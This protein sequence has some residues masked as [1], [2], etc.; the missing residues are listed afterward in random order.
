MPEDARERLAGRTR[1]TLRRY[2]SD[3]VQES[4]RVYHG[5]A[6]FAADKYPLSLADDFKGFV[7]LVAAKFAMAPR[8]DH[9]ILLEYNAIFERYASQPALL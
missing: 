7:E 5:N 2:E 4:Y 3:Q 9:E 1:T 6:C 8:T